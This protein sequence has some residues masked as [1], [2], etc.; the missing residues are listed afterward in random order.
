VTIGLAS[1]L[2]GLSIGYARMAGKHDGHA[3]ASLGL[4]LMDDELLAREAVI[5]KQ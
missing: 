1:G 5:R 4:A 3:A 2:A